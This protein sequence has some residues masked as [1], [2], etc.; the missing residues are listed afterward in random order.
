MEGA[1]K[2]I[3]NRR[4]IGIYT[5]DDIVIEDGIPAIISKAALP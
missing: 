5:Y 2:I 3:K 1:N 4:Y